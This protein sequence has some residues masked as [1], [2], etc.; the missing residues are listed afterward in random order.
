MRR[1]KS[2]TPLSRMVID[3]SRSCMLDRR[4]LTQPASVFEAMLSKI[5]VPGFKCSDS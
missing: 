4:E 1:G 5:L 3:E 2:L